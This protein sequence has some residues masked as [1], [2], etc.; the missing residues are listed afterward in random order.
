MAGLIVL[1]LGGSVITR[2][3]ENR[4]EVNN[5]NL[6]RLCREIFE[7]KK[8]LKCNF[9]IVHGAGPF[10]HTFAEKYKLTEGFKGV[11][12]VRGMC[13]THASM[14]KLNSAVVEALNKAGLNAIALQPSAGGV[15]ENRR[16][17]SFPIEVVEGMIELGL[18]PVGYGDVLL[19][20][21]TGLN[22]LS[23]D[24]LVPYLA[25]ELKASRIVIATDVS[26]IFDSDPKKNKK[27]KLVK[28]ITRENVDRMEISG[29]RGVDVTGG[30]KRKV[31]E[32]LTVAGRGVPSQVV[33]GLKPGELKRA[34][35]GDKKLGTTIR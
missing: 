17:V 32:L 34:L 25:S 6:R 12:S 21:K 7:A 22:I 33:S 2:K 26:G 14:E 11:N 28:E 3:S 9:I 10:G 19:D 13:E 16:L 29:S 24:H 23:G 27:A 5:S 20:L 8:K 18:T 1:K 4:L 30:M 35:L 15:L 31:M